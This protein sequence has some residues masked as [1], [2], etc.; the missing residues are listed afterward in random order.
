ML[1]PHFNVTETPYMFTQK[2][3]DSHLWAGGESG[4]EEGKK[5]IIQFLVVLGDTDDGY[6]K[7]NGS[8]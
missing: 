8:Q 1:P 4:E 3:R 5:G 6:E 7:V 2:D